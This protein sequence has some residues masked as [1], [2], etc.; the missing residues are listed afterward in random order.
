MGWQKGSHGLTAGIP[1]VLFENLAIWALYYRGQHWSPYVHG[2]LMA[3]VAFCTSASSMIIIIHK[4]PE[5]ILETFVHHILG[6]IL[7]CMMLF[8]LISGWVC[9]YKQSSPH[10]KPSNV[11]FNNLAHSL[12]GWFIIIIAK[13]PLYTGPLQR[14][15]LS[16]LLVFGVLFLDLLSHGFYFYLKFFGKKMDTTWKE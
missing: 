11:A 9:K 13:I 16:P 10:S 5:I 15:R 14:D 6:F 8:I 12:F 7:C 1:W 3:T 4:G 2:A